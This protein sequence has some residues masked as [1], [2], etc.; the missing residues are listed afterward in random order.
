MRRCF[1]GAQRVAQRAHLG[2]DLRCWRRARVAPLRRVEA[3]TVDG[4]RDLDLARGGGVWVN[5]EVCA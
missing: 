4:V 2:L 5:L 3:A 1:F